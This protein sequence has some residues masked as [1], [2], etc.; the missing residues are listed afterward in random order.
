MPYSNFKTLDDITQTFDVI[1]VSGDSLFK[2]AAEVSTSSALVN[3]LEENVPLAFNINT[4][5]ARSEFIIA[6]VI[7]EI[8]RLLQRK[9][10][11]FSGIDFSVDETRNLN[12][13]CDFILSYSS[14]QIFLQVPVVCLVEAKNDNM[15]GGYAQCMA[16]MIAAQIY[17]I[18][19][20]HSVNWI[21]GV[22]TTG[23]NWR[24]LKLEDKIISID[25]DEYLISHVNKILGIFVAAIHQMSVQCA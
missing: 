3:I 16:E 17:N 12:G 8:R 25:F 10:S 13:F 11:L 22:V 19:R 14:N 6:P 4:E 1:I 15:K 7:V 2:E 20:G 21:L 23:S 24:F 9:V 18:Q 5:K